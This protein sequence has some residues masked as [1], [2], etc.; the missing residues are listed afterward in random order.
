MANKHKVTPGNFK[1]V[2]KAIEKSFETENQ[3]GKKVWADSL[4]EMLNDLQ[5]DDFFGTEGQTDPRG[6]QRD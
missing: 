3:S 2:L 5:N 1:K 6:D 4:E